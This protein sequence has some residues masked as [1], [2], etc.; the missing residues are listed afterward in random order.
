[1]T[2]K[3]KT[4]EEDPERR[5]VSLEALPSPS[6]PWL[7]EGSLGPGD[8]M[9]ADSPHSEQS[10]QKPGTPVPGD[11]PG[12]CNSEMANQDPVSEQGTSTSDGGNLLS[13]G[14]ERAQVPDLPS[15]GKL[16]CSG[17][18]GRKPAQGASQEGS[19]WPGTPEEGDG[20]SSAPVS[21]PTLATLCMK[22]FPEAQDLPDPRQTPRGAD[23]QAEC[24][25]GGPRC[26]SLGSAVMESMSTD[27]PETEQ[28]TLGAAGPGVQPDTRPLASPGKQT[29]H[30]CRPLAEEITGD[31]AEAG[32]E[33]NLHSDTPGSPEAFSAVV[34][35][36][37]KP[38]LDAEDPGHPAPDVGPDVDQTQ[39]PDPTA[40]VLSLMTQCGDRQVA[41]SGSQCLE[42]GGF[43]LSLALCALC[44][45]EHRAATDGPLLEARAQQGSPEVPTDPP[46]PL[47]HTLD[48][49]SQAAWSESLAMELDFL[50][51]SQLRDALDAPDLEAPLE[52][53]LN[54]DPCAYEGAPTRN[55]S[56][57]CWPCPSPSASGGDRVPVMEA[58]PRMEDASN[59]VRGLIL[60][61]SNLN[62][63]IMSTHRDIEAC[64]RLSSRKARKG[65]GPVSCGEQPRRD[66]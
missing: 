6:A 47:Q 52:Q 23:G 53:G 34:P 24:S 33:D 45:L 31:R 13:S 18:E 19:A 2:R 48:S 27:A 50:P 56:S 62:R 61:L 15:K 1:M 44:P 37:R 58:Q 42:G 4:L 64:K 11:R 35:G 28:K 57:L 59:M 40:R 29:L 5:A 21:P 43:G 60:E 39:V 10:G 38:T 46:G 30:G 66:L 65:A 12:S 49:V 9:P 51:D 8:Q 16:S 54:S 14:P 17:A 7:P 32:P 55:E 26:T 63:L 41:E 22:T 25:C 20:I 36:N 3:A